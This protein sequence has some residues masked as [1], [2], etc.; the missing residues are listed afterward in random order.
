MYVF[1][2]GNVIVTVSYTRS[3]YIPTQ[4]KP[5]IGRKKENARE[6]ERRETGKKGTRKEGKKVKN[7]IMY[8]KQGARQEQGKVTKQHKNK[9]NLKEKMGINQPSS[10][11]RWGHR[12]LV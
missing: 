12:H 1:R 11:I 2:V 10:T 4:S 8:F 6:K 7:M 9:K 3:V 5:K